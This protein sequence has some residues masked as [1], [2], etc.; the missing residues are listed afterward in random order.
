MNCQEVFM[1]VNRTDIKMQKIKNGGPKKVTIGSTIIIG[2]PLLPKVLKGLKENSGET[3]YEIVIQKKEI[4]FDMLR[5]GKIDIALMGDYFMKDK[6][7]EVYPIQEFPFV[8]VHYEK[9]KKIKELENFSLI[10]RTDSY[11]LEK[12]IDYLNNYYEINIKNRIIINGSVKLIK[13]YVKEKMG[14]AILPYYSVVNEIN[15]GIFYPL[16]YFNDQKD[17]YQAVVLRDN[18]DPEVQSTLEFLRN[19]NIK[20]NL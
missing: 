14:F 6:E 10:A 18:N 3:V 7:F 15:E 8:L 9:L 1:A 11:I 5:E 13:N 17:G 2:E 20:E 12:N 19:Y 16:V 4:L